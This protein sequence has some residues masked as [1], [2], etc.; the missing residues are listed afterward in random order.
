MFNLVYK[1]EKKKH[2]FKEEYRV[3]GSKFQVQGK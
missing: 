1:I 2:T 3:T